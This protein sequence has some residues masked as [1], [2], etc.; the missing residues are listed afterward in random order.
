MSETRPIESLRNLGPKIAAWLRESGIETIEELD[1]LG[2]VV[3]FRLVKRRQKG[4]SLNLLWALAAG[5]KT[6]IGGS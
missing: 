4:A 5:S 2:P 1:R 3:A 6:K